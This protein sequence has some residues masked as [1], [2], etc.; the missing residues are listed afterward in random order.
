MIKYKYRR[1]EEAV[2]RKEVDDY[3]TDISKDGWKI[4]YYTEL[5]APTLKAI[6]VI[7]VLEK[8]TKETKGTLFS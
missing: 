1:I 5:P 6:R 4:I 3:L 8:E 2:N 7:M